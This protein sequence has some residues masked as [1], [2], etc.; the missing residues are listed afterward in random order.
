MWLDTRGQD[1]FRGSGRNH[2]EHLAVQLG[3]DAIDSLVEYVD[4]PTWSTSKKRIESK[5][6][7]RL[8]SDALYDMYRAAPESILPQSQDPSEYMVPA[9]LDHPVTKR[10]GYSINQV[11]HLSNATRWTDASL[12]FTRHAT[13]CP[14]TLYSD[15]T[16]YSTWDSFVACYLQV[17]WHRNKSERIVLW[18]VKKSSLCKCG[19]NGDC[20]LD[21]LNSRV[22][23]VCMDMSHV[24]LDTYGA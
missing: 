7:V 16:P 17:A 21:V 11:R 13:T 22:I 4:V 18:V 14:V 3:V 12:G 6:P 20:T 10:Y 23:E 8:P 9:F 24:M 19:C 15:A 1:T 2:A 5:L